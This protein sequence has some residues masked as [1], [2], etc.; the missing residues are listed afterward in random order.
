[1][2][3]KI[4]IIM[5]YYNRKTLL[6][7][8]L[9][10]FSELY[11]DYNFEVVIADD[12]SNDNNKLD[13]IIHNYNFKI[14]L[15]KVLDKN[16]INPCVAYNLAI[17]HISPDTEFVII[18]NP[19]IYHFTNMLDIVLKELKEGL[20]LTFPVFS[21]FNNKQTNNYISKSDDEFKKFF[22]N[23]G[24]GH[25]KQI[26]VNKITGEQIGLWYNH[27]IYRPKNFHFLS[28]IHINDLKKIGG[29]DNEFKD[30]VWF[31]DDELLL[32]ISK[33]CKIKSINT[34]INNDIILG[35]HQYHTSM[36][37][38]KS[39]YISKNR[40]LWNKLQNNINK[41]DYNVYCDPKLDINYKIIKN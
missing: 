22:L 19:E 39:L 9:N 4:S 11:K 8:T 29:F 26:C 2:S 38:Q 10:K 33:I 14:I 13:N 24:E 37:V 18:Q 5:G 25:D 30:G 6:I 20:Y 7:N 12:N 31:D 21:S 27:P 36:T 28:G 3:K 41:K 15:L 32:R 17:S 1:M 16:W 23:M 35:L 40:T 34:K